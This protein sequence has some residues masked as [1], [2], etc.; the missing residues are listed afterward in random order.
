MTFGPGLPDRCWVACIKN[1]DWRTLWRDPVIAEHNPTQ[2]RV[3]HAMIFTSVVAD[4]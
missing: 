3:I 1:I 2:I 4:F